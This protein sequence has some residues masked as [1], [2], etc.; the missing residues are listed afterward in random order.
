MML[1]IVISTPTLLEVA[2]FL[3]LIA[4]LTLKARREE[5]LWCEHNPDY[6]AYKKRTKL[7][8]PYL[9]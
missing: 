7:F 4:T 9:L 2:M 1:G 8:L 5:R 6:L 3:A